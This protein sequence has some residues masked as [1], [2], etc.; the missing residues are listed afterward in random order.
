MRE[1]EPDEP[2][3]HREAQA[4]GQQLPNQAAATRAERQAHR[5][6]A[7]PRRGAR[8]QQVP[9]IRAR[10]E[11]HEP[12][13]AEQHD[14]RLGEAAAQRRCACRGGLQPQPLIEESLP[15]RRVS[16][17]PVVGGEPL[18]ED[19]VGIRLRALERHTWAQAAEHVEPHD[20]LQA[21]GPIVQPVAPRQ[22]DRLHRQR[23]PGVGPLTDRL[24]EERR[25]GHADDGQDTAPQRDRPAED[26]GPSAEAPLPVLVADDRVRGGAIRRLLARV[27]GLA[28]R[29]RHAER[30]EVR[31]RN[32]A[33]GD[34]FGLAASGHPRLD[35]LKGAAR[36]HHRRERRVLVL[37]LA[38]LGVG[39]QRAL[40][41]LRAGGDTPRSGIGQ[42]HELVRVADGERAHQQPV[43]Q[44]EDRGVGA[45]AEREREDGD[46]REPWTGREDADGVTKVLLHDVTVLPECGGY[47][48]DERAGPDNRRGERSVGAA[49]LAQLLGEG[50]DHVAPVLV[51][52]L[53]RIAPQQRPVHVG[54]SHLYSFR[55]MSPVARAW[56]SMSLTRRASATATSL[57]RRVSR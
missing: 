23:N 41:V 42:Q 24:A 29:R 47:E 27:E 11:Q 56:V 1:R 12:C 6:L 8:Q 34:L 44:A 57:P 19:D 10:D 21:A 22:H 50:A 51:A 28:D 31:R 37:H 54:G 49:R 46:G 3:A 45:D 35:L 16:H 26:V 39:H 13:G 32:Q 52:K 18:L 55:G 7:V 2:A 5:H 36:R 4:F 40:T 14:E 25:R 33:D 30:R 17:G 43:Q 15:R 53:R 9:E 48:I 38:E 20:L